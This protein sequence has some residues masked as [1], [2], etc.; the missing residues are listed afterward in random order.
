MNYKEF[1]VDA[2]REKSSQGYILAS[3]AGLL[4]FI[5]TTGIFFI[6]AAST[7][8]R[9]LVAEQNYLNALI[10]AELQLIKREQ[11]ITNEYLEKSSFSKEHKQMITVSSQGN[12]NQ[13]L[14]QLESGILI[15]YHPQKTTIQR[16]SWK[17]K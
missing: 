7:Q 2:Y 6:Q 17:E 9:I 8:S 3:M 11:D 14:V 12:S 13:A 5:T 4:L 1:G 15:E 10:N 16:S